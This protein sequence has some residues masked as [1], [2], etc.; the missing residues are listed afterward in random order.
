MS[1]SVSFVKHAIT[2]FTDQNT[3]HISII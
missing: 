1:G 3:L 2:K